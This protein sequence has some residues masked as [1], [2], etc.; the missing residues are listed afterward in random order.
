MRYLNRESR[1]FFI[2]D[3]TATNMLHYIAAQ[4]LRLAD[5]IQLFTSA[6]AALQTLRCMDASDFPEYIFVDVNMPAMNGHDFMN[7]LK[8]IK[9]YDPSKTC[10][11]FVTGSLKAEDMV[12][13]DQN[14]VR[15][16]KW[17][18]LS[19]HDLME[20]RNAHECLARKVV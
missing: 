17:K 9:N 10:V 13:A 2:D 7:E 5:D 12:K 15:C 14:E 19:R 20:I 8:S 16:Y 4:D 3:D 11:I 18:P 1:A 6:F